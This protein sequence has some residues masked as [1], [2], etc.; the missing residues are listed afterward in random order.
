MKE[1]R[2]SKKSCRYWLQSFMVFIAVQVISSTAMAT[3]AHA[4]MSTISSGV[5]FLNDW[6]MG[7]DPN[8]WM[9]Y[10][11]CGQPGTI[12]FVICNLV[13]SFED[14]PNFLSGFCYLFG[15]VL[16]F[17]AIL[18]L[19]DHV[20]DPRNVPLWEPTKRFVAAGMFFTFPYIMTVLTNSLIV[21]F[22]GRGSQNVN[23]DGIDPNSIDGML[24]YLMQNISFP[25]SMLLGSFSWL[26]GMVFI[27]IG[28]SRFLKSSQDGPRGPG[29]LGTM[30]TFFVGAVL[31]SIDSILAVMSNSLFVSQGYNTYA[32]LQNDAGLTNE[33]R[34]HVEAIISSVV[35]FTVIVGW[36]SFIR[37]FFILREH[38][39]GGGQTS[40]MSAFTHILA[41]TLAVNIGPV[42]N[43]VQVTLGVAPFG[44][45]FTPG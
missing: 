26:A 3:E 36:V 30:M 28:V 20:L 19:K 7:G 21:G 22:A 5:S 39:D 38:A 15:V 29:G 33:Q 1:N 43:V 44:V 9:Q 14:M 11:G 12:G 24:F 34:D 4:I 41:G 2:R 37:G 16:G 13:I 40:L 17:L 10:G 42:L 23:A 31:M 25:M 32:V 27:M 45:I 18:K 8:D 35:I 6:L